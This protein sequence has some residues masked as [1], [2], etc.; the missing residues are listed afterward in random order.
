MTPARQRCT[1]DPAPDRLLRGD[2]LTDW[3]FSAGPHDLFKGNL[4][5]FCARL[6]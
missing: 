6:A 5:T 3:T 1:R 2:Y 4:D